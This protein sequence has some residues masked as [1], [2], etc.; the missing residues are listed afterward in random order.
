MR[1]QDGNWEGEHK[2]HDWAPVRFLLLLLQEMGVQ[3]GAKSHL[4]CPALQKHL[5]RWRG[6]VL[7]S[8]V[9]SSPA[10]I[11]LEQPLASE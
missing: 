11:R 2:D 10:T 9:A 3:K 6:Y 1:K 4:P 8:S 7:T 5:R